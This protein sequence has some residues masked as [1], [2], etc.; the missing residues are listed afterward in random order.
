MGIVGPVLAVFAVQLVLFPVP[1]G[2]FLRG[3][4]IG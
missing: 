2:V 3:I 1:K 4:I